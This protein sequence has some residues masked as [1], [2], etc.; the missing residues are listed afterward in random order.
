[1]NDKVFVDTN[2]WVYL[3]ADDSNEEETET[4]KNLVDNYFE[5]IIISTHRSLENSFM[6]LRKKD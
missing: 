3:Y 6:S 5:N 1:M 4:I 2:L